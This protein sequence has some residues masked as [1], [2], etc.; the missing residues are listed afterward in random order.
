MKRRR[1]AR[2]TVLA[3]LFSS[4]LLTGLHAQQAEQAAE[5]PKAPNPPVTQLSSDLPD[6]RAAPATPTVVETGLCGRVL[7]QEGQPVAG[8]EIHAVEAEYGFIRY[9]GP[10]DLQM[11]SAKSDRFLLFFKKSHDLSQGQGASGPDG[12][13]VIPRLLRGRFNVIAVHPERGVGFAGEVQQPNPDDP[14]QIHLEP[15]AF[16]EGSIKGDFPAWIFAHIQPDQSPWQRVF[17]DQAVKSSELGA[18][19]AGPL[20]ARGRWQMSVEQPVIKR[21]FA[22]P[23]L[24]MPIAVRPGETARLDVDLAAG[25]AFGGRVTGPAGEPLSDVAVAAVQELSEGGLIRYGALTGQDGTYQIRGVAPGDYHLVAYRH[26]I[27]TGFG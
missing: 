15:P 7:D 24:T 14:L 2:Q 25:H 26:E 3:G 18:F 6:A 8:A 9:G 13:F 5:P 23:L 11:F 19:R 17:I 20:P 22:A 27:K 1:S 21:N 12:T 4:F 10:N 16:I